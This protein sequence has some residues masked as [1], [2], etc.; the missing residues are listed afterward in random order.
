[1]PTPLLLARLAAPPPVAAPDPAARPST[2]W[3]WFSGPIEAEVLESQ[4]DW[5]KAN[6]F[7][8]V[9]IAWVYPLQGIMAGPRW[10]SPEWTELVA[11]AKQYAEAIGLGCDF[12]FGTL[13]PFGGS[14]V[15]PED[16]VQTFDGPSPHR[17]EGTWESAYGEEPGSILD[18]LNRDALARYAAVMGAALAPALEGRTSALFCDSWEVPT[19]QMWSPQLWDRFR[20]RFGYDLRPFVD[21][22]AEDEH[23]CYDYRTLIAEAVVEEFYRPFTALCH[24]LGAVSRVQCHGAPTDLLAAYAAVDIPETEVLL[25]PPPFARIAASA[26]ALAG[27]PVVSCETFTCPYGFPAV[28]HRRELASDLKLLADAV[29]AHG[30]NQII[31]HGMPYNPPG[32]S[33]IFFATVHV[34]P[35]AAFAAE[36]PALNAFL[37]AVCSWMRRGR[38]CSPLAVYLPIEDGRM[39]GPLPPWLRTPAA[40]HYW[41]LRYE[42]VPRATEPFHPL[43]IS[44]A[45][46]RQASWDGRRLHAGSAEFEALYLGCDWLDAAALDDVLRLAQAGLPVALIGRPQRPGR[47]EPG[48]YEAKLDAL[49]AL[50][51]VHRAVSTLGLVPLVE[52]EDL[53]PYWAR[54]DGDEL[55]LFFAHPATRDV[56]YPMRWGQAREMPATTCTVRINASAHR[57]A[58]VLDF[59]PN[60]SILLRVTADGVT[61]IDIAYEP[62][63]QEDEGN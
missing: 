37:A 15:P 25:F 49:L 4:L 36:I 22:L 48:D 52:G 31:W 56:R 28:H 45:F 43:W 63:D 9:E 42:V 6:G 1:M 10:L 47:G 17:L 51:N 35:D 32:G 39:L 57:H 40:L 19:G 13:W 46:L 21:R 54:R 26:A 5:A 12:T 38:T 44:G 3:W 55:I 33:N 30:V 2:R 11:H 50:P 23:A 18:H 27:R 16:A 34:G 58:I 8:G 62:K 53:P 61:P 59:P 20:E 24:D 29:I 60:Q 14:F 41:E 7:G